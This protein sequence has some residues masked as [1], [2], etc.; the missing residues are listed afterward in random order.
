MVDIFE[1]ELSFLNEW[2]KWITEQVKRD[3]S[4]STSHLIYR[5]YFKNT[6]QFEV[7]IESKYGFKLQWGVIY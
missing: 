4:N 5:R 7:D 3:Y 6:I 1:N 2:I